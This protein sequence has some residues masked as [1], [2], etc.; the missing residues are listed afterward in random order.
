[1]N[2]SVPSDIEAVRINEILKGKYYD[3]GGVT[4]WWNTSSAHLEGK[5]PHQVWLSEDEP[6]AATIELVRNAARAA[7]LMGHAT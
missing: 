3:S 6:W 5:T 1:M 7:N 4:W 2:S